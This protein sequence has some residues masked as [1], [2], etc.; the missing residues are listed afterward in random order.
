MQSYYIT[1][2]DSCQEFEK[3]KLNEQYQNWGNVFSIEFD[4][5][6]TKLPISE[7]MNVFHFTGTNGNCC[8][9]GDRIP[10]LFINKAGYFHFTM[11]INNNGNYQKNIDFELGKTYH[12]TIQQSIIGDKFWYEILINDE[13]KLKLENSN[14]KT[15]SSVHLYTSDS[16]YESFTSD[17]GTVCNLK[18]QQEAGKL[19]RRVYIWQPSLLKP[20]SSSR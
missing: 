6:I 3:G 1:F 13:S 20:C 12:V 11:A 10:A 14:P 19:G 5:M 18:I 8:G 9:I 17:F 7:W 2:S 16:W 4:I 15:F